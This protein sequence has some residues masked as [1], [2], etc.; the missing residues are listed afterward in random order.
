MLTPYEPART[1]RTE[2]FREAVEELKSRGVEFVSDVLK[3]PWR[4]VA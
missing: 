2:Q 3:S 4:Y 1:G